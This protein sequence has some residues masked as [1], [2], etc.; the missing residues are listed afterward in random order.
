[1]RLE[2]NID[3][4]AWW[5]DYNNNPKCMNCGIHPICCGRKYPSSY[6]NPESCKRARELNAGIIKAMY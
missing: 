4:Y 5:I 3:K 6:Y 2:L 1:M